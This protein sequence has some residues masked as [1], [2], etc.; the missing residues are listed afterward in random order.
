[1]DLLL[2]NGGPMWGIENGKLPMVSV[3]L[4]YVMATGNKRRAGE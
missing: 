1:M 4:A 2:Q 3:S